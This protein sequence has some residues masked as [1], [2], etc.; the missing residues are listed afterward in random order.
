MQAKFDRNDTGAALPL[1]A[2]MLVVLRG[3]AAFATDLAWFYLNGTRIQRAADAAALAGVVFV[4]DSMTN[5]TTAALDV[6]TRN[7]YPDQAPG[8][9]PQVVVAPVPGKTNQIQVTIT[10]EVPT[11]FLKVFGMSS[12]VIAR[13]STAEFV[14]PLRLGSPFATMGND[15]SCFNP[16]SA[17]NP[18]SGSYWIG[19][20][21]THN[22]TSNGDPYSARCLSGATSSSCPVSPLYRPEGYLFGV[23]PSGA[24]LTIEGLDP[25]HRYD[26]GGLGPPGYGDFYRTGDHKSGVSNTTPGPT[27]YFTLWGADATPEVI[28]DNT[29]S[30]C[31]Q[32][33]ASVPQV[34]PD[35]DPP[36]NPPSASWVWQNICTSVPVTPGK[37][38]VLQVRVEGLGANDDGT[39]RFSLRVGGGAGKLFGLRDFSVFYNSSNF[40]SY[41]YLAEV[42]DAY[43]GKTFVV[44]GF[45][46]G[47]IGGGSSGTLALYQPTGPSSWAPFP[48][49]Q[50]SIKDT[51]DDPTWASMGTATNCQLTVNNSQPLSSPQ[52]FQ[53]KWFKLEAALPSTYTCG[54]SC[55]WQIQYAFNAAPTDHVTWKAYVV[56]NPIHLI[57]NP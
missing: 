32:T 45:D 17:S 55:W 6:A 23:I 24:T 2:S 21:G 52:N 1:A 9:Y 3:M 39:N 20:Y 42:I 22:N 12:Q 48:T 53:N 29:T 43:A 37:L 51:V 47:D 38:Y 14:P 18:C 40:T 8:S 27:T 4:N 46:P 35:Q 7:G 33:Y 56:G 28:A 13:T 26:G 16:P 36:F 41:M 25:Q 30:L 19:I 31:N 49:C 54:T 44:E 10:D 5:V 50:W 11:F 15:P 57:P 34:T